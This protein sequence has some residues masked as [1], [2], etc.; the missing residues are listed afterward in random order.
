MNEVQKETYPFG[1][2]L[3]DIY[4]LKREIS[5]YTGWKNED[6]K[7][8]W[9]RKCELFWVEIAFL[10]QSKLLRLKN[11]ADVIKIIFGQKPNLIILMITFR[12]GMIMIG[13][14]GGCQTQCSNRIRKRTAC[15]YFNSFHVDTS[16]LATHKMYAV[17]INS[18]KFF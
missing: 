10:F 17:K 12:S 1:N 7:A 13:K 4:G 14:H 2:M 8:V 9:D 6:L 3:K 15:Q 16:L 18:R 11:S 5:Y